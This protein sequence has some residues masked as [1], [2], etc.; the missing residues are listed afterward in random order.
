MNEV[1]PLPKY[2]NAIQDFP[3]PKSVKHIRAWFG[4]INHVSHYGRVT[5]L[6]APFKPFLSTKT[7]FFWN[8]EL[9]EAFE[10]SKKALIAAIEHGVQIFDP[11]R[12]TCLSPD[13]SKTG[14]GYW[15]RQKYCNCDSDTPNCCP[16]GWKI[17]LAGS[18]F[19]NTA[20]SR[21]LALSVCGH[22]E[23]TRCL[24]TM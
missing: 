18:R 7:K 12:K 13:W 8:D 22:P 24:Q 19:L 6:M 20:Y 15:L 14:V 5:E 10:N 23:N 11:R 17:T 3:R 2:L 21:V 9:D 16:D 4:L 1:K